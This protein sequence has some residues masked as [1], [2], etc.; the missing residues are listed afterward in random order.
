MKKNLLFFAFLT[1]SVIAAQPDSIKLATGEWPPFTSSE[2]SDGGFFTELV[3]EIAD[4]MGVEVEILFYPWRRCYDA[5]VKGTV[6]AAFP[7]SYTEERAAEVLYSDTI[8]DSRSRLFYYTG[9]D[10][11]K[12]YIY[13]ELE[14]LGRYRMGGVIGYF[15]EQ[16]FLDA[17]I[18]VDYAAK[19]I[20]AIEKLIRGRID[21]LPL[22]ELVG[23]HLIRENFPD[24]AGHFQTMEK[25]FEQNGLHLIVS[26]TYPGSV[27]LAERLNDSL[28]VMKKNAAFKAILEKYNIKE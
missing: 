8:I 5:V 12:V 4:H 21:L 20:Q 26:K 6:W 13:N 11:E 25:P 15:Y 17:G 28:R 24:E 9:N 16:T 19:E 18:D 2:M 14:D 27:A 23:W 3:S 10:P 22:N 7:Y 1:I